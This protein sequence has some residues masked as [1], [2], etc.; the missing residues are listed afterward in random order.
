MN[1]ELTM[2]GFGFVYA[3]RNDTLTEDDKLERKNKILAELDRL[4]T[5]LD[6]RQQAGNGGLSFMLGTFSAVDAIMIPTFE[7]WR[8]QSP[9]TM[10]FTFKGRFDRPRS[11]SCYNYYELY[12]L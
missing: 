2:A 4:N 6:K 11:C 7:R 8:M 12:P 3:G 5:A 1:E 9:I 10:R